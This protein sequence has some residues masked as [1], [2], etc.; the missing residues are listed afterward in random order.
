MVERAN[1]VLTC[2]TDRSRQADAG[3]DVAD[4]LPPVGERSAEQVVDAIADLMRVTLDPTDR[5]GMIDY[6]NT[7]RNSN[8]STQSSPFNGN[9]TKH[10]DERVRGLLYILAQHPTYQ[11]R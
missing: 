3:I 2:I 9:D 5:T 10:I 6:L 8:G 11:T 4:L 1:L 7:Q